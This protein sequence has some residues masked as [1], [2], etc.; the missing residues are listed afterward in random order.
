MIGIQ[1]K[2][3][4]FGILCKCNIIIKADTK[5]LLKLLFFNLCVT[6]ISFLCI[7][8]P[9]DYRVIYQL[10]LGTQ[11]KIAP[12]MNTMTVTIFK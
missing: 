8:K 1:I 4:V 2:F 7:Q 10:S 6:L 5:F 11:K 12:R 9:I 3:E